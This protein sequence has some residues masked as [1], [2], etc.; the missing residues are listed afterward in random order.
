MV[1]KEYC[2][3]CRKSVRYADGVL[4]EGAYQIGQGAKKPLASFCNKECLDKFEE[5]N[6]K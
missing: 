6:K 5:K 2:K 1:K 3:T 4:K